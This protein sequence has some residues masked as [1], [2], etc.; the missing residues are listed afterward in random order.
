MREKSA[1][2]T[3]AVSSGTVALHLALKLAGVGPGDEVMTSTLTFIASAN[4]IT[5][6]GVKPIFMDYDQA[7]W[8]LNPILL[9]QELK[10]RASHCRLHQSRGF[11]A[12][13]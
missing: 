8:N 3:A 13:L 10:K 7:S 11:S 5:Y 9:T 4:P 12:S 1:H 2:Y 6:L